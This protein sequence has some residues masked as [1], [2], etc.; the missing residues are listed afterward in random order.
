MVLSYKTQIPRNSTK[1]CKHIFCRSSLRIW[2]YRLT[3]RTQGS[4]PCNPGS[5]PGKVTKKL[6]QTQKEFSDLFVEL[7]LFVLPLLS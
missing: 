1:I 5:I 2:P 4:H 6:F 3:V 7:F